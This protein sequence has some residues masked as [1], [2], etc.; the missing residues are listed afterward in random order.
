[1]FGDPFHIRYLDDFSNSLIMLER[2]FMLT[3]TMVYLAFLCS[4]DLAL[5]L[6]DRAVTNSFPDLPNFHFDSKDVV[7]ILFRLFSFFSF[8]PVSKV[9]T[10]THYG[11]V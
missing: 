11:M 3:F 6:I 8:G 7:S 9:P 2:S 5:V 10:L 4:F 1:M